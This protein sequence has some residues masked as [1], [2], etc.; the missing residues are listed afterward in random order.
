ML[1]RSRH[2]PGGSAGRTARSVLYADGPGVRHCGRRRLDHRGHR[3]SSAEQSA[4]RP[5]GAEGCPGTRAR[6]VAGH[7]YF[8]NIEFLLRMAEIV[9]CYV[10]HLIRQS[11]YA[12]WHSGCKFSWICL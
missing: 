8:F 3:W 11:R 9:I 7:P 5:L 1:F 2:S 6:A 4:V 12:D 10:R